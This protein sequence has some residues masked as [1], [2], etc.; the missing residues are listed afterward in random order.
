[1]ATADDLERLQFVE[2]E[3]LRRW[4]ESRIQPSLERIAYLCDALGSPQLSYPTIH[5]AGTNGKTS[6]TRMIDQIAYKLGYR[7]GRFT[8]P[9]LE[10]ITERISINNQPISA[11]AFVATYNDIALYLDMVDSRMSNPLSFFEAVTAMAFV[12]FAEYPVDIGV[13]EVGMGGEWDAT[14]VVDGSVNVIT[15]IGL[16]HMEYLGSTIEEIAETKSGII[17]PGSIA[18]LSAQE[19]EVAKILIEKCIELEA[20]PLREGIEFS[21]VKREI[22]VGGQVITV[23]GVNGRYEDL[24]LPL[25]GQHQGDNATLAIAA[26]EA[27]SGEMKLDEDL[28]RQAF[29]SITSPGRMEV[30]MRDPTV[31]VDAAHNPHGA[32]SLRNTLSHEFNF[33]SLVGIFAPMGDKDVIGMLQVLEPILGRIILTKNSSDRGLDIATLEKMAR[34]VFGSDRISS[35]A[36]LEET[37]EAGIAQVKSDS[38]LNAGSCALLI[39]GS[40]VS[41]GQARKIVQRL[42]AE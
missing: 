1:M 38:Q 40:V 33:T 36:T 30:L 31:I 19:P 9:H 24:F 28:L 15:P 23:D 34:S 6:T 42:K 8:S 26:M 18:V 29:A 12:A 21:L 39:T 22:A 25:Y 16:D 37:I 27:F 5:I 10:K 41:A 3:L 2:A 13:I 32:I 7:T 17:K 20:A 4:P 14:N 35:F 11:D